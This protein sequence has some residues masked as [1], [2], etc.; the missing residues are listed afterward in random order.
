MEKDLPVGKVDA[1]RCVEAALRENTLGL[2][3]MREPATT[4]CRTWLAWWF[5]VAQT[6]RLLREEPVE[7]RQVRR[8]VQ[9]G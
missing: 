2:L 3:P 6:S 7:L 8:V 1:L 9:A 5:A 4:G